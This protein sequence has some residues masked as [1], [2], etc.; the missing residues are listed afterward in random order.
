MRHFTSTREQ[1]HKAQRQL[2]F[3]EGGFTAIVAIAAI[4]FIAVFLGFPAIV[5]GG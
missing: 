3:I 1:L 4:Y 2:A 5:Q